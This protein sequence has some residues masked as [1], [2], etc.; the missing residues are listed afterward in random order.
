MWHINDGMGWWMLVA[1]FVE[2]LVV[3][4]VVALVAHYLRS[5]RV[6]SPNDPAA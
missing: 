1:T 2:L 6:H 3:V 4:V 5:P